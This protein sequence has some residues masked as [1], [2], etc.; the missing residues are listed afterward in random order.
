MTVLDLFAGP[1][2]WSLAL[3]SLGLADVGIELDPA[4]CATR[5]AAGH[6][7][8][9][10]DVAAFP[11]AGLRGKIKGLIGSPP[12]QGMS[13]AGLHDGWADLDVIRVLLADLAAGRDTRTAHAARVADPRS[14]LIAEPLRHALAALP[15]WIACEQVPAV[16]PLWQETA[17]HL[18]PVGYS[19]WCGILDAADFGLPQTRR[20][21]FLVASRVR[22]VRPPAP[23]HGPD[24]ATLFGP[25]LRRRVSTADALGLPRTAVIT[26]RGRHHTGGSSFTCDRPSWTVT[27]S[28][29]SWLI[30]DDTRLSIGQASTLQ[31]FPPTYP[32][33]GSNTKVFEQIGNAVPPPLAAAVLT[34]A[35]GIEATA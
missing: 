22:T 3:R 32:W 12:C 33:Q 11:V 7:A 5:R 23:T 10:A 1:G 31:G 4:A 6:V 20:R 2:G 17:R 19:T 28:A 34:T 25:E 26:T 18:A 27:K 16:L 14:L 30:S 21:A 35:T 15:E 8:V 9:C 13:I 24:P 29:R